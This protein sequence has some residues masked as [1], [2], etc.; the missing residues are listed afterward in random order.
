[1]INRVLILFIILASLEIHLHH[2]FFI[3]FKRALLL[4]KVLFE[5]IF[6][7][8]Q[9]LKCILILKLESLEEKK[10]KTLNWVQWPLSQLSS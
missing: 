7:A 6:R 2:L 1:M 4:T 3:W 5:L 8:N 10:R 9:R